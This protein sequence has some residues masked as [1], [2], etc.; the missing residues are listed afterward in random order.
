MNNETDFMSKEYYEELE[1][2]KNRV[3]EVSSTDLLS[4]PFCG[5]DANYFE[6]RGRM[7]G[8]PVWS[9]GCNTEHCFGFVSITEFAR[10]TE[11]K[12]A[13]NKRADN[14]QLRRETK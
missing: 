9:V 4:C 8:H 6:D 3:S 14:K 10:K 1:D 5:G 13:W 2:R 12:Q 7:T 11:A